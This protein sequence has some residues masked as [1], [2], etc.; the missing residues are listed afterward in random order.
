MTPTPNPLPRMTTTD[1]SI[2]GSEGEAILG[3]THLPARNI[4]VRGSLLICHGFKGYKDYGFFPALAD[5]AAQRGFIAHRF[6]FSHSGMTNRIETFERPDLFE[7]DTFGKQI[8]DLQTV[9]AAVHRGEI[10]G[11]RAGLPQAWFGHSRGGMAVLMTA[12]RPGSPAPR[13]VIAAAAP[14]TA[15]Y[16]SVDQARMLRAQGYLESPSAR[17]GQ[18]LRIGTAFLDELESDRDAYE[19]MKAIG[20]ITCPILLVHGEADQTVPVESARL[21]EKAA[22]GR[23]ELNVI[24]DAGHTF[25]APNPL[26]IG[27][28]LP[29]ATRQMIDAVVGFSGD[30]GGED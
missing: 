29:P 4:H 5:A 27:Q 15:W 18:A 22:G 9:A 8:F 13:R 24:A 1:W 26:P 16:L 2:P 25:E 23:A 21:L 19:P 20:Q 11:A 6:N 14:H 7:A 30:G 10:P 12:A 17:T 3:N 28:P